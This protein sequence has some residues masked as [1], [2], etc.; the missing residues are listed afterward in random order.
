[1]SGAGDD[2][3]G[4]VD[5]VTGN[6]VDVTGND[7][8]VTG[9]EDDVTGYVGVEDGPSDLMMVSLRMS[10]AVL[11]RGP[12]GPQVVVGVGSFVRAGAE[13]ILTR[14]PEKEVAG[15]A[16]RQT[17]GTGELVEERSVVDS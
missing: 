15:W 4:Y 3:T 10:R 16:G 14:K 1:L 11:G 5:D 7:D 2:D 9:Y 8:D 13:F 12:V 6:D 17:G